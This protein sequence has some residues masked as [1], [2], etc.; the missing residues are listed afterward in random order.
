MIVSQEKF[1]SENNNNNYIKY[2]PN[3]TKVGRMGSVKMMCWKLKNSIQVESVLI[4]Y[5]FL[6]F[7]ITII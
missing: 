6:L 4:K 1:T 2:V 7:N 3:I 5:I